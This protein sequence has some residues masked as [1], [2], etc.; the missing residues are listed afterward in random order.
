MPAYRLEENAALTAYAHQ[1]GLAAQLG[2]AIP[3][4]ESAVPQENIARLETYAFL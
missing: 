1:A 2:I 4:E 3:M